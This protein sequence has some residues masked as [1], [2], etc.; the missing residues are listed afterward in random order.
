MKPWTPGSVRKFA[1]TFV[2]GSA[3][4]LGNSGVLPVQASSLI[5]KY[6][7]CSYPPSKGGKPKINAKSWKKQGFGSTHIK[8]VDVSMWQHTDGK[9]INFKKLKEKYGVKFVF[10]KSSDGGNRDEGRSKK[11]F[12]I[13]SAAARK[14]GLVVG[15]YHYAVPG[16]M[17]KKRKMDA[18]IQARQAV[19][20]AQGVPN[21]DLPITLD[22]EELPC[23]WSVKK[24]GYWAKDYV[25][26]VE[27]LIGRK[28]IIYAN[29]IFLKRLNQANVAKIDF[30]Q[31][32]LW[33]AQW[34]PSLGT[35]PNEVPIWGSNWS[36]WQFTSN[37]SLKG[38]P[39]TNTDLNV[40]NGTLK[41]L[42]AL[43]LKR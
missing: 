24:L 18:K 15:G 4:F 29:G 43:T 9:A 14:E 27:R 30:A 22:F 38:V 12:A 16:V 23:G 5:T 17:H 32:P 35:T 42:K 37:G 36:F 3:V 20:Q 19:R 31:Y 13:D 21:G 6:K 8:G 33:T 28:P 25:L 11:W 2:L 1:L 41:E 7:S 26:E 10:I 34:G 39:S 40:F